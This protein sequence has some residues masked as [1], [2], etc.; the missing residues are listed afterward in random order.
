[1]AIVRD[2]DGKGRLEFPPGKL[3]YESP[4]HLSW[5]RFSPDGKSIAFLDHPFGIDDRGAVAMIDLAGRR[6]KLSA[7]FESVQGLSWSPDGRE[8]WFTG[9]ESGAGRALRAVALSGKGRVVAKVPGGLTLRDISK[10]GLVLLTHENVRKGIMGLGPGQTKERELS[11]L[12]WSLPYDLSDDGTTLLLNEQGLA[13]GDSY[14]VCLRKMDG[15]PVI[16]LGEGIPR[17]LSPDGKWVIASIQKE[18]ANLMILPTGTGQPRD[19]PS[20]NTSQ[21]GTAIWLPDSRRF[22]FG[23]SEGGSA[24]RLFL[25]DIDG[26]IPRPI[27]PKGLGIRG[28]I[29][30]ADGRTVYVRAADGRISAI[31]S[32]GGEARPAFEKMD[33]ANAALLRFSGDGRSLYVRDNGRIPVSLFRI[34]VA[35]GRR[36]LVRELSP[37]D[38]AGLQAIGNIFLSADGRFYAYGYTRALSDLYAVEGLR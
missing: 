29:L 5:P 8:V 12:E 15:S 4:G 25:Q 20:G 32:E 2:A 27:S 3:L 37:G 6:T 28:Y 24:R 38:P 10:A 13:T 36:E 23:A 19:L 33:L 21:F 22:L 14:A 7:D 1:M 9:A 34:D 11:W 35:S 30:S 31:P 26:G 16:R 18:H 17:S